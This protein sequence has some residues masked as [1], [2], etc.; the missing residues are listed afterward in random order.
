[1]IAPPHS[2]HFPWFS[3]AA[4]CR[5]NFLTGFGLILLCRP[6]VL[7][8]EFNFPSSQDQFRPL[9]T[10]FQNLSVEPLRVS[11]R[12]QLGWGNLFVSFDTSLASVNELGRGGTPRK[13]FAMTAY[14]SLTSKL[15]RVAGLALQYL[16]TARVRLLRCYSCHEEIQQGDALRTSCFIIINLINLSL[17]A[18]L[19]KVT[20]RHIALSITKGCPPAR[21]EYRGETRSTTEAK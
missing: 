9:R 19:P 6:S 17:R 1:M 16:F 18:R 10:M 20:N 13:Q 8:L 7:T 11:G 5:A 3:Y 2:I 15:P 21:R 4:C 12:S 14:E